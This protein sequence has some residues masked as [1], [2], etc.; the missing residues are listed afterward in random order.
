MLT[1]TTLKIQGMHC[2]SCA[3]NIDG[4]LEDTEGVKEATTSYAK[5]KVE[6]T[7]DSDMVSLEKIQKIIHSIGYQ[8]IADEK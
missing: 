8:I 1:K 7:F 3:F 2:T 4:E 6:V 5:Q